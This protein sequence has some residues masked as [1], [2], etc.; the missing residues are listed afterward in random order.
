MGGGCL[1]SRLEERPFLGPFKGF[2]WLFWPEYLGKTQLSLE[3]VGGATG[4]KSPEICWG[5]LN[6]DLPYPASQQGGGEGDS[7]PSMGVSP[8]TGQVAAITDSKIVMDSIIATP[9]IHVRIKT[10]TT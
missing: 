4:S 1:Q 2:I 6:E 5:E 10:E 7:W 8:V 3:G 9:K